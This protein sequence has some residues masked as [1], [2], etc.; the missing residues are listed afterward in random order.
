MQN[1]TTTYAATLAEIQG[2]VIT[3]LP[4]VS[5]F[6]KV[7]TNVKFSQNV[8]RYVTHCTYMTTK[9][10]SHSIWFEFVFVYNFLH[11]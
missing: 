5:N 7:D 9:R 2:R 8:K 3:N 1:L 6:D 4:N 11:F 10:S